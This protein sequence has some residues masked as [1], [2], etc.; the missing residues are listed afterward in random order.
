M[1]SSLEL[2]ICLGHKGGTRWLGSKIEPLDLK[3]GGAVAK[4]N[5]ATVYIVYILRQ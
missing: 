4:S 1:K 5:G 3:L 2:V